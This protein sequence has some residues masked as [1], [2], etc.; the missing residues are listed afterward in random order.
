LNDPPDNREIQPSDYTIYEWDGAA[1]L[2]PVR[3]VPAFGKK[4]KPEALLPLDGDG[5]Q[6]R[7]LI[8]FD[9]PEEGAPR[10]FEVRLKKIAP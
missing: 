1:V 9:G 10:P 2:E 5:Q 7:I 8:L 4:V 6:G 3:H